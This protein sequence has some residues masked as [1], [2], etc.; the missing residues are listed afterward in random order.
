MKNQF[1]KTYNSTL[2]EVEVY[3]DLIIYR[4]LAFPFILIARKL[5]L[6][7]NFITTI[8]FILTLFS[9]FFF[10]AGWNMYAAVFLFLAT[11]FD[12]MDGQL[13]RLTGQ[14]SKNGAKYDQF[15]DITGTFI[16]FAGIVYNLY[17]GDN[18]IFLLAALSLLS[19]SI[20]I[21][22]FDNLRSRYLY[23]LHPNKEKPV[24]SGMSGRYNRII[25]KLSPLPSLSE[26]SSPMEKEKYKKIFLRSIYIWS[27][28]AGTAH[29]NILIILALIN[30]VELLWIIC[31]LYFS[32]ALAFLIIYQ[33]IIHKLYVKKR[34]EPN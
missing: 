18:T 11:L 34:K 19:S 4:P 22:F 20:N 33:Y 9:S 6:S 26:N 29:R 32:I 5:K 15:A 1:K 8:S 23:Q 3:L 10:S 7:P 21:A 25:E 16:I 17:K 13:A 2:K 27:F 14:F 31:I 30:K 28:I 12:C 24:P